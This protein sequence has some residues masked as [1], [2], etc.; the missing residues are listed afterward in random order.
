MDKTTGEVEYRDM[1]LLERIAVRIGST[2]K[3]LADGLPNVVAYLQGLDIIDGS[4]DRQAVIEAID[5]MTEE[6]V[7]SVVEQEYPAYKGWAR[8]VL[9]DVSGRGAVVTAHAQS[10]VYDI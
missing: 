1:L 9:A 3:V 6:G 8:V 4:I 5:G 7:R 2:D 10:R